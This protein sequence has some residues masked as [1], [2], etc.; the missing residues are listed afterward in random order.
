MKV[1]IPRNL[2]DEDIGKV[3]QNYQRPLSEPTIMSYPLQRI[4]LGEVCRQITDTM[5][6][7]ATTI[8]E[9]N[10]EEII[11]LDRLF[12]D[13][14]NGLPIFLRIDE[15]SVCASQEAY[16]K[17]PHLAIQRFTVELIANTRRCKF[18]QPFLIRGSLGGPYA[19]SREKCLQSARKVIAAKKRLE[20]EGLPFGTLNK[21]HCSIIHHVF[22]ATTVLVMDLCFNKIEG[23]EAERKAEVARACAMLEESSSQSIMAAKYLNSLMDILRKHKIRV[24]NEGLTYGDM[25][26]P[27]YL[28]STSEPVYKSS[29]ALLSMNMLDDMATSTQINSNT[30]EPLDFDQLWQSYVEMGPSFDVPDWDQ[31]FSELDSGLN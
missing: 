3:D 8:E 6:S 26:N 22:M 24:M 2:N 16:R 25:A 27:R 12:D 18:H 28:L 30:M 31:I 23:M 20:G 1:S 4:R 5:P 9:L 10:Y 7:V 11:R 14:F 13:Y 19:F 15:A 29:E 21:R 17:Y